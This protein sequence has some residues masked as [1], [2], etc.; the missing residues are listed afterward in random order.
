MTKEAQVLHNEP[1]NI[2]RPE[3]TLS[4][5]A[6]LTFEIENLQLRVEATKKRNANVALWLDR[7]RC[8]VIAT[9]VWFAAAASVACQ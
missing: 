2:H 5:D 3:L 1:K 7:C 9:P 6:A 4:E 8:G